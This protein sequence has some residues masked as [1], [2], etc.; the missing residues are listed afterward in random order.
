MWC[1]W[2]GKSNLVSF[3]VEVQAEKTDSGFPKTSF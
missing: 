3:S 1:Y 2:K